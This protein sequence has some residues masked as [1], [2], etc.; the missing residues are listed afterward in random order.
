[1]TPLQAILKKTGRRVDKHIDSC[2]HHHRQDP[3]PSVVPTK[4]PAGLLF[5]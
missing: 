3:E 4:A 2:Y 5:S 1:M